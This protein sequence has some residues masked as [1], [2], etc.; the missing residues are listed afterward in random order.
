MNTGRDKTCCISRPERGLGRIGAAVLCMVVAA[1]IAT[2]APSLIDWNQN[3]NKPTAEETNP[4]GKVTVNDHTVDVVARPTSPTQ[5]IAHLATAK[6]MLVRK[7]VRQQDG[8]RIGYSP[9][10]AIDGEL[11]TAWAIPGDGTDRALF[12]TFDKPVIVE[13]VGL[14][15]GYAKIDAR[16]GADRY[17]QNR[18][19]AKVSWFADDAL[20][21]EQFLTDGE[22]SMQ[23]IS[24]NRPVRAK[25][26]ALV[27]D[28]TWEPGSKLQD[29][30]V[31]SEISVTGWTTE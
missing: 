25:T 19:V 6:A 29:D 15:N 4:P 16:T 26:I 10:Q 17:E 23:N 9:D 28:R 12:L 21:R 1:G 2:A 27:I 3:R 13:T 5:D 30:T 7:D 22:R 20:I 14:I 24:L 8:T 31:I 11:T 18:R